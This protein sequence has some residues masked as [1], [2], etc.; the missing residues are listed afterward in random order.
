MKAFPLLLAAGAGLALFAYSRRSRATE[1]PPA[2]PRGA[3]PPRV[4]TPARR[5]IVT[6]EPGKLYRFTARVDPAI[7]HTQGVLEQFSRILPDDSGAHTFIAQ[8]DGSELVTAETVATQ[9]ATITLPKAPK[10]F[11]YTTGEALGT[12]QSTVQVVDIEGPL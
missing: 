12:Q 8:P 9:P 11:S 6:I 10:V 2:P 1:P 5:K 3:P 4:P 7:P